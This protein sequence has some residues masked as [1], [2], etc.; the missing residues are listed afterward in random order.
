MTTTVTVNEIYNNAHNFKIIGV[1]IPELSDT[2][3]NIHVDVDSKD[4]ERAPFWNP[5]NI[6]GIKSYTVAD[7]QSATGNSDCWAENL[8]TTQLAKHPQVQS[9][10][11][12]AYNT[13][14][15]EAFKPLKEKALNNLTFEV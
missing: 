15:V 3:L 6:L 13:I 11:M 1:G 5:I 7:S 12:Q 2:L 4:G 10:I 14:K 9:L 8:V